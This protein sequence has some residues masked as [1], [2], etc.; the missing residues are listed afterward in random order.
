MRAIFFS[1]ASLGLLLSACAH[2]ER[3]IGC[4][5]PSVQSLEIASP[6]NPLE[7]PS[8]NTLESSFAPR[9]PSIEAPT[10]AEGSPPPESLPRVLSKIVAFLFLLSLGAYMF[11]RY[12]K[13]SSL[14]VLGL[15]LSKT[16]H[17][18]LQVK[19]TRML[20]HKQFLLVVEYEGQKMLLGTS[21][22]GIQYLCKLDSQA[23]KR[24]EI[25]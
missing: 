7:H 24:S 18:Q 17:T 16:R 6:S 19:E 10:L 15:G 14:K 3:Q 21:P 23:V 5:P 22:N 8:D 11:V 13:G 4:A 9:A 12:L 20:G 2:K 1:I 25:I